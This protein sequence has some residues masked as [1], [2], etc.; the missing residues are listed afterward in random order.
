MAKDLAIVLNNGSINSAVATALAA[1]KYRPI[2]LHAEVVH[3]DPPTR[4][5]I[6]YDAQVGHFKPFREQTVPMPYLHLA[7]DKTVPGSVS[8]DPRT[9]EPLLPTL[10]EMVPLIGAALTLAVA[11]EASAIYSGLRVG[12]NTDELAQ[13]TEFMQIWNE[14]FQLTLGR[15][16]LELHFPVL[17]MEYWQVIDLGFQVNVPFEKTWSCNEQHA[18]ACGV[19]RGCRQRES[20]FMQAAKVDPLAPVAAKR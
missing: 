13:A 15:P 16:D 9:T 19:C 5:K 8:N 6:A 12:P 18:D 1:Q 14:M 20:S 11:Y 10:R 2:I 4:R 17:E 7:H 3:T